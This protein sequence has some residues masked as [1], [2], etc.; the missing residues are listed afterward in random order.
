[1]DRH[2]IAALSR[3]TSSRD[4]ISD[5]EERQKPTRDLSRALAALHAR[6]HGRDVTGYAGGNRGCFNDDG[7]AGAATTARQTITARPRAPFS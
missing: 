5:R 1:M 4:L 2:Q 6:H 3:L 7:C